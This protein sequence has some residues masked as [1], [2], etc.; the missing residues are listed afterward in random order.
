MDNSNSI[1]QTAAIAS[2]TNALAAATSQA[3]FV[4]CVP[5]A[6]SSSLVATHVLAKRLAS[7]VRL[8]STVDVQNFI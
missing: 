4:P 1:N 5:I 8:F 7:T 2:T 3:S 6:F